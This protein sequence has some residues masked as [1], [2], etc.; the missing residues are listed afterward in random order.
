MECQVQNQF[1]LS[2]KKEGGS[3]NPSGNHHEIAR[4]LQEMLFAKDYVFLNRHL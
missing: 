2:F 1:A 3:V 4:M